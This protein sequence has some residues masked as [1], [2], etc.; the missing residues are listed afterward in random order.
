MLEKT[1]ESPLDCK[2]IKAVHP[3]G[4]QSWV[5]I[6]RTDAEA[7][8]PILWPLDAKSWLI[9]KDPELGKIEGK[10][11]R[12]RQ[13]MRCLDGILDSMDV[14]LSKLREIVEDRRVR[15]VTKRWTHLATE[16][17]QNHCENYKKDYI[18]SN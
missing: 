12:G 11:R 4:D 17:Q 6:G 13:S 10:I 9:G 14:N 5:F 15:G 16:Q 7:E 2:E 8:A 1:L 3:K 18:N